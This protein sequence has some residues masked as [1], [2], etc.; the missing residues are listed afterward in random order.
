MKKIERMEVLVVDDDITIC[1]CLLRLIDW[2]GI[3]CGEPRC[4]HNGVQALDMIEE[5]RPDIVVCDIKMPVMDGRELCRLICEKYPG[6][7]VFFVSAYED[8][9]TAQIAI[10]Y[11]VKGY[12][13][14]PL[15]KET[16]IQLQNM[17]YEVVNHQENMVFCRKIYG[18]EY[19]DVLKH[20]IEER[21]MEFPEKIFAKLEAMQND[22]AVQGVPI[23]SH[24]IGP[25]IEYRNSSL[26]TD[27]GI[28]FETERRMEREI[29]E[30]SFAER[31]RY[32]RR[33]YQ[34]A[35]KEAESG[36]DSIILDMQ[37]VIRER[38]AMPDLDVNVL[39][40]IYGMS[41][42]Y[43]GRLFLERTGMKITE[44]IQENRI[45]FACTRLRSS[46]SSVK[47]IAMMSG[48]RDAGYFNK[49]FRRKMNMTPVEYREKY[50]EKG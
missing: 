29:M 19:T 8:F 6:I 17:I 47:E 21:N 12:V 16:L 10:R 26:K 32:L 42:V 15:D 3:G 13:L 33:H 18:D 27:L 5:S 28:L 48:Y 43:L 23:W 34:E 45:R 37:K 14:K 7:H 49:V 38:F 30:Y 2:E 4:A 24:L 20:A 11:H 46:H 44:Y 22:P 9:A 35:M 1:Q 31:I 40:R 41:P 36:N 25:L 39:A 50:W